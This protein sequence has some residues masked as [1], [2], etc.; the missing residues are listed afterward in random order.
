[1]SGNDPLESRLSAL[2]TRQFEAWQQGRRILVE[3]IAETHTGSALR[4]EELLELLI[5]EWNLRRELGEQPSATEYA[6]RFP[7]LAA[8]FQRLLLL[9]GDALTAEHSS[10]NPKLSDTI[11]GV[12]DGS[13]SVDS[14]NANAPAERRDK[15]KFPGSSGKRFR[16]IRPHAKGGLGEVFVAKDEE[17]N[18]E[19]ALKEIQAQYSGNLESRSRFRLEAE[20][21]GNLE[22]PGIVPV[23]GFGQ[24]SDGRPFYAMRF[25]RGDSLKEAI[26]E[27]HRR[28]ALA[29]GHSM[30]EGE[31][32]LELRKLLGRFVDVCNAIEYA[33]SRGVLHRDLKPGNIVLGKYGE[34]LVVDWGLAKAQGQNEQ[35]DAALGPVLPSSGSGSTPTLLG[36]AIG[37]P[38][39]MSPEQAAGQ[40][41]ELGPATDVY[42]LGATLYHLLTGKPP[43]KANSLP[44]IL[45]L[46]QSGKFSAPTQVRSDIPRALEAVCLKAMALHADDRY[47]SPLNL[48]DDIERWLADEPVSV[49]REPF[50]IRMRRFVR[51]HQVAVTGSA[52]AIVVAVVG[53]GILAAVV[54]ASNRKLAAARIEAVKQRDEALAQKAR[55]DEQASIATAVNKFLQVDLLGQTNVGSQSQDHGDRNPN[56]TVRELLDRASELI[57]GQFPDQPL[58]EA[59][60]RQ[61]IGETYLAL[62]VSETAEKNLA[63]AS[64]LRRAKLGADH[65]ET[66]ESLNALGLAY[67]EEGR[68]DE[69][70]SLYNKVLEAQRR[71]LGP[72]DRETVRTLNNM[73]TLRDEQGKYAEAEQLH[74][75]AL[76]IW[77]RTQGSE[78]AETLTSMNNL[79]VVSSKM[80]QYELAESLYRDVLETQRRVLGADHPFTLL[81]MSN[82]AELFDNTGRDEEALALTTEVLEAQR[83]LLGNDHPN[84]IDTISSLGAIQ[85]ELGHYDVAESLYMN[86]L[87]LRRKQMGQNHPDTFLSMN[88]LA[89]LYYLQRRNDE[90]ESLYVT[91][92]NAQRELLGE[93]HP[94]TL[95]TMNN[96]AAL[97]DTQER[98]S[99]SEPLYRRA[100]ETQSRILGEGHPN[101]L[102]SL[103]NLAVCYAEQGKFYKAEP[104]MNR[105]LELER[106][107]FADDHP[108]ILLTMHNLAGLYEMQQRYVESEQLYEQVLEIS[109]KRP[110]GDRPDTLTTIYNLAQLFDLQL[111]W[112]EAEVLYGQELAAQRRMFGDDDHETLLS[113]NNLAFFYHKQSRC[114]DARPLYES[115]VAGAKRSLGMGHSDTVTITMNLLRLYQQIGERPAAE[116]ILR[117]LAEFQKQQ[118]GGDSLAYSGRLLQ[119]GLNLIAQKKEV[120][121]REILTTAM[122]ILTHKTGSSSPTCT[123]LLLNWGR[124]QLEAEQFLQAEASFRECLAIRNQLDPGHW[125]AFEAESL[126]GSALAGQAR[127]LKSSSDPLADS[128]FQEAETHLLQAHR[129][130]IAETAMLPPEA[131]NFPEATLQRIIELYTAWGKPDEADRRRVPINEPAP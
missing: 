18:R 101:T 54:S 84:T 94:A 12:T 62:G 37:T 124:A 58:V 40:I 41:N 112:D 35:T 95:T 28:F 107:I 39:Y 92:L 78:D 85:A 22:H 2:R 89:H 50:L 125:P 30:N 26:E 27:F 65:R 69:A 129:G 48:A 36:S 64:E 72:D 131:A 109:R 42:S 115:A 45:L 99:E 83:R 81:V 80:G 79:A 43:V 57:E 60:I 108:D 21:T 67:A 3:Q 128:K 56:I 111:R 4:E 96:L 76:E 44:E 10:Q 29:S 34:T 23:Y 1:M 113:M 47:K 126:L 127:G 122:E 13:Q 121:G 53:L 105:T 63:R 91:T 8:R 68:H 116:P 87:D 32:S 15:D 11:L 59:S 110:G 38:A 97:F 46:V 55:A 102:T 25:I 52:A 86:A 120:E 6:A 14:T 19:V 33:H 31:A 93:D 66:L 49:Y 24:Y 74:R 5:S 103:Q 71:T 82:L 106:K 16:V 100:L 118:T 7:A 90:A 70:E 117:D 123:T 98:Y 17:L 9:Q 130:L 75:Q 77:R 51:R 88:N 20:I 104:L 119:L 73:A 61:T 114:D